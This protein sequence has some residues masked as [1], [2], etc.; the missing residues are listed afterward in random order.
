M[1][2]FKPLIIVRMETHKSSFLWY[3]KF[4]ILNNP[5]FYQKNL[6]GCNYYSYT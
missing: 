5:F 3:K 6:L 4:Q 1:T 2:R